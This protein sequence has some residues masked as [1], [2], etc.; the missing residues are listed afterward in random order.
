VGIDHVV[1]GSDHPPVPI[2]PERHT[3]VIHNLPLSHADKAKILGGNLARLL[4][5]PVGS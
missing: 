4:K 5:L 3:A 1:F 2:P